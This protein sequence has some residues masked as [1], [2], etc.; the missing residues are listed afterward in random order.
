LFTCKG[1]IAIGAKVKTLKRKYS[2]LDS[3]RKWARE[4]QRNYGIIT[5]SNLPTLA[6]RSYG[7]PLLQSIL[8][9]N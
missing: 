5:L 1:A 3:T 4:E 7:L 8:N 2:L 6:H 9:I